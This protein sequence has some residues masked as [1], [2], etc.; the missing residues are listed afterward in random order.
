MAVS[1]NEIPGNL[2]VPLAYVE[3]DNSGA[4]TGTP[5]LMQKTLVLGQRLAGSEVAAGVPVRITRTDQGAAAFGRGSML[6]AQCQALRQANSYGEVWALAV[7]EPATGAAATGRIQ[8]AGTAAEAGQLALLMTGHRVP[9]A[10]AVGDTAQVLATRVAAAI[11]AMAELPVTAAV[12]GA[13]TSEVVLTAR[14]KGLTGNDIDL[15]LNYY[16]DER[17]PVGVAVTLVAMAGG[18]GSPDLAP[19]LAALGDEW[20]HYLV[21]P[22]TDTASLDALRDELLSRWGP[23]R[24]IDGVAFMAVRGTHG[25]ASTFGLS[26]NDHLFSCIGTGLAPQAPWVWASVLA[27]VAA[28]HL[29]ID[30]ARPLQTLPLIG[31]LPPAIADRWDLPERNLLL[32]DGIST[33]TVDAGGQVRLERLITLYRE[34]A[35]GDPDP[36]YLDVNTIATLSYIR[37][38]VRT[39][40]TQK[41]PRHKLADDGIRVGPGQAIVTPKIIRTELLA[42]FTELETRGLVEDFEAFKSTLVVERNANDRNRLDVLSHE[43]LVNQFRV[44]AHSVQYVL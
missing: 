37:Y 5:T 24:Q 28:Y 17:T 36:S 12:D 27:G 11:N 23:L 25:E 41:F 8:L 1:F 13:Q 40:I 16:S 33:F 18:A 34:N 7:D 32:Y 42:L 10:V 43:N 29:G 4:V 35:Y 15:R 20:W 2:R 39:R 31:L 6:A 30:P 3:F 22:F 9:V 44:Y 19:A 14:W 21:N 26:R 38:A